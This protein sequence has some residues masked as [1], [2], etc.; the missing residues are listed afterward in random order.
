[1]GGVLAEN[2]TLRLAT[3]FILYIAQGVPIGL[4]WYA[5]PAWMAAQGADAQDIAWVLGLTALPWSLKFVNGL[6]MDRYSFLPMGRR[7]GWILGAQLV[8]IALFISAAIIQPS[9]QDVLLLGMLSFIGNAATT[10]QDVGVDGMAVD[11]LQPGER[12]RGGAM[13]FG[14]QLIGTALATA[15][16]GWVI[17]KLGASG[18][19]AV[20]AGA[21][22][23]VTVYLVQVRERSDERMLPWTAGSTHPAN[24]EVHIGRWWPLLKQTLAALFMPLS[25]LWAI[26]LLAKG[27]QYGVMAAVTPVIGVSQAGMSESQLTA[28]TGLAQL[29][30]GLLGLTAGGWLGTKYGAKRTI[31]GMLSCWVVF[32]LGMVLSVEAWSDPAFSRFFIP[33]WFALDTLLTVATMP[34]AMRL[35]SPAV[36]ATQFTIY[37]AINNFGISSGTVLFG[38]ADRFGGIVNVFPVMLAINMLALGVMIF[39]PFPRS[40]ARRRLEAE[41]Q[42]MA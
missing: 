15:G 3:I 25:L 38:L 2:R 13:M 4:F 21:I 31:I 30:A 41:A 39:V 8:M 6:L 23:L 42:A 35:C 32:N 11:L 17:S 22:A 10:F 37:M 16:T 14:G 33:T 24:L 9:A 20:A 26:I 28:L 12:A 18:A 36:A 1:M 7:R 27:A 34:I 5:I 29:I 40:A 19:Y